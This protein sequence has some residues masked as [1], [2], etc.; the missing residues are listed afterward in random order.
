MTDV[1]YPHTV[2]NGVPVVTTPDEVDI[3]TADLLRAALLHATAGRN[4]VVVVDMTG[5]SFCDS[6]GL[7]T[8]L[9]AHKRAQ[10]EGGDLRVVVPAAGAVPRVMALTCIDRLIPCF[11]SLEEALAEAVPGHES[12]TARLGQARAKVISS[13]RGLGA[14]SPGSAR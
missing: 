8:L 10:A 13:P 12:P 6:A 3:S 14:A 11:G 7:H 5:T 9:A 1:R 4:P 2:I